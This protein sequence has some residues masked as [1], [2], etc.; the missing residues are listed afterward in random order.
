MATRGRMAARPSARPLALALLA[1]LALPAWLPLLATEAAPAGVGDAALAHAEGRRGAWGL[2]PEARLEVRATRASLTAEHA[3]VA[4]RLGDARVEDAGF[5]YHRAHDGRL[6]LTS[7]GLAP[8]PPWL[9]LPVPALG[10][11]AARDLALAALGGPSLRAPPAA[12]LLLVPGPAPALVWRVDVAA[13][14]PPRDWEVRLDAATGDL[15]ALRDA[16][17]A[18][19]GL[20][21]VFLPNPIVTARDGA[22]RDNALGLATPELAAQVRTVPLRGLSE[23]PGERGRL[24]GPH[25]AVLGAAFEPSLQFRYPREDP[26]FEEVMAYRHLDEAQRFL[27]GLGY[28]DLS[29]RPVPAQ[30]YPGE[31]N[32]FYS[33]L[34]RSIHFGWHARDGFQ[35]TQ[36][37]LADAAEDAEVVVHEYGH[38]VLDDAVPGLAGEPGEAIHEGFADFLAATLLSRVSGAFSDA[39][40]G[41]W[42]GQYIVAGAPPCVRSLDNAA[43]YPDHFQSGLLAD[44]HR[45]GLI[46]SGALWD[47][48]TAYGRDA[49]ERVAVEAHFFLATVP[50]M[51]DG[52]RALL[53]ANALLGS[54]MPD[55]GMRAILA[56]R[57][58]LAAEPAT[59]DDAGTGAD[60]GNHWRAA[61]PV[62]P[63]AYVGRVGAEFDR[64]DWYA[65]ALRAGD[66]LVLDVDGGIAG[67]PGLVPPTDP[68]LYGAAVGSAARL[69][70][71][72][73]RVAGPLQGCDAGAGDLRF[74]A[75]ATQDGTW[76]FYVPGPPDNDPLQPREAAY[77]WRWRAERDPAAAAPRLDARVE[78]GEVRVTGDD[79]VYVRL[80]GASSITL[81]APSGR[82]MTIGKTS[83]LGVVVAHVALDGEV[84]GVRRLTGPEPQLAIAGS[85]AGEPAD[86]TW[87]VRKAQHE[88]SG[89]PVGFQLRVA[90][91][92]LDDV[93]PSGDPIEGD[94]KA[95]MSAT[96]TPAI[97]WNWHQSPARFDAASTDG[98]VPRPPAS[99]MCP[100]LLT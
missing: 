94:G 9:P 49:A 65:L 61:T 4:Q 1:A 7:E 6:A 74:H 85:L 25:V 79:S 46:W 38:A 44:P 86:G 82:S 77:A 78:Q 60:A 43:R 34:T 92:V 93:A 80:D 63:G 10:A 66:L 67:T 51:P 97:V 57:G 48:W 39:C 95:T 16:R 90:G 53:V 98:L 56:A 31:V 45:N 36:P 87:L 17:L 69:A 47:L 59:Q 71:P 33:R 50:R 75:Y 32:A 21:D 27:Q 84:L 99:P 2:H 35:G 54:P 18:A 11:E 96:G 55:A 26:R 73:Q 13:A 81:V 14:A 68:P 5:A 91:K 23:A 62:A 12:E 37:G 42:F 72:A 20:G 29:N 83:G 15:L 76:R 30:N 88:N 22:L 52:G 28:T 64:E 24:V 3:W 58:L 19:E 8:L 41:E 70:A 89:L 100:R 40:M